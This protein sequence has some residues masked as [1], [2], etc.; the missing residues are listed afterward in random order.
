MTD[1]ANPIL[2]KALEYAKRKWYVF[3][4]REKPGKPF[5]DKD[6]NI[7]EPKEKRP[8]IAGGVDNAS[9]DPDQLNVWWATWPSALIGVSCEKSGL[10]VLDLDNKN[11]KDGIGYF[12][13]LGF[14]TPGALTSRTPSGGLH[15]VFSG[16]GKSSTGET[17]GLDTRGIG[18]Y[19]IAPPSRIVEGKFPGEYK[20]LNDWSATPAPIPA[21]LLEKLFPLISSEYGAPGATGKDDARF[22]Y[23]T[24]TYLKQGAGEGGRNAAL[25]KAAADIS[26]N[27]YS[28]DEAIEML[29]PISL[30]IGLGQSEILETIAHA[31]S[32]PRTSAIPVSIQKKLA[33][34]GSKKSGGI[35]SVSTEETFLVEEALIACL[36]QDAGLLTRVYDLLVPEDFLGTE[37]RYIYGV[38]CKLHGEGKKVDSVTLSSTGVGLERI[39]KL[40]EQYDIRFENADSYANIIKELAAIRK[41]KAL[42]ERGRHLVNDG[43]EPF[44]DIMGEM[45]RGLA[46]V[47]VYSGIRTSSILT[48]KQAVEITVERTRKIASGEIQILKT[49]FVDFDK[50][51][52][53][54]FPDDL[55][56][57]TGKA[58]QGKS[59][60]ALSLV[61]N[62]GITQNVP[63][64]FFTLEMSTS[65]TIVRLICQLTGLPFKKV[66]TGSGM[67]SQDWEVYN[68]ATK[69]INASPIFFEDGSGITIPELRAKIRRLSEDHG[70]KLI[71][72]D[73][74]E[75]IRAYLNQPAYIQFDKIGY[76]L[77]GA[78]KDFGIPIALCHQIRVRAGGE[79]KANA[80]PEMADLNQAGEK[81]ATII[82]A[83]HHVYDD[84]K[85]ITSSKIVIMKNRN[86]TC[87]IPFP[88][89]FIKERMF[90]ANATMQAPQPVRTPVKETI[91]DE[92]PDWIEENDK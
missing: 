17:T 77:K 19:I 92:E 66:M 42:L 34:A 8:Y 3:P 28:K 49:G 37:T 53:G 30:Q 80:D 25:F 27:G 18:G 32:K 35:S 44:F 21:G 85:H 83:I 11:G 5:K 82:W 61:H 75:Q 63:V 68:E 51:N 22:A 78:I 47:S 40:I 57:L 58:G 7:V 38:I 16:K 72:I 10:F 86:G 79:R 91:K 84:N 6:G 69:K 70:I 64:V 55:L 45:E 1:A 13:S 88:I 15:I 59:G 31:Y 67:T 50:V 81:S 33:E 73:Q 62:V 14:E 90:F 23:A 89:S 46:D 36:A 20:A 65:E 39:T 87:E 43:I 76:D 41:F 12:A 60:L 26:G 54:L 52:G 29:M 4:C 48:A 24:K 74:L 9:I 2:E 71:V 56:L